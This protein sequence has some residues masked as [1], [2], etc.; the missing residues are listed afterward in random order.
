MTKKSLDSADGEN[1]SSGLTL[2][3]A[4]TFIGIGAIILMT[5]FYYSKGYGILMQQIWSSFFG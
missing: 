4:E 2:K 1:Q 5:Y 3:I